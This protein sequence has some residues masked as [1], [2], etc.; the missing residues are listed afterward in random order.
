MANRTR[1]CLSGEDDTRTRSLVSIALDGLPIVFLFVAASGRAHW[2]Y[3]AA[4]LAV[5]AILSALSCRAFVVYCGKHKDDREE[6]VFQA[7]MEIQSNTTAEDKVLI[8]G[9]EVSLNFVT[10]R[11]SPTRFIYQYLL[12]TR[13]Y[14]D[15]TMVEAFLDDIVRDKP[16]LIIDTSSSNEFIP[17]IDFGDRER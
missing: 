9:A 15:A 8:W 3:Y 2:H 13:G 12:Y 6:A 16:V 10:R 5:F 7:I 17:P 1:S 14:Q 11:E 4:W